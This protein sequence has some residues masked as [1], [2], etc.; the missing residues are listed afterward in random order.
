[1]FELKGDVSLIPLGGEFNIGLKALDIIAFKPYLKDLVPGQ[2]GSL[3][4][5]LNA[6]VSGTMEDVALN[7]TM[8]LSELDFVPDAMPDAALDNAVV[9]IGY[10]FNYNQKQDALSLQKLAVDF[11]GIKVNSAG[12]IIAITQNP[13]LDLDLDVPPLQI[14]QALD[15]IPKALVGDTGK[16][17][18]AGTVSLQAK[19]T[20]P[21]TDA[22]GV[23][24]SATLNLDKVQA[25]ASGYRPALS[26]RLL[27]VGDQLTSEDL[28]VLMGDNRADISLQADKLF[29]KTISVTADVSSERF[30]LDPL[31]KGGAGSAVA[32][33]QSGALEPGKSGADELGPFEIPLH[34]KGVVNVS[35]AV[36]KG[37]T[38]NNFLA[39]YEL[40]D[41]ILTM[42]RMDGQVAGG[43]FSNTARIDLGKKGLVY[44]AE[45][46]LNAIQADPLLSALIPKAAGS[47]LG[48]MVMTLKLSGRGTQWQALS[49]KLNGNG[50]MSVTD[51][52]IVSPGLVNGLAG[53]LQMSSMDEIAF[54]NFKGNF[55]IVDGKVKLDSSITSDELKL[56]P[57]GDIGLDGNLNLS[58]D[59]RL[60][61]QL[62]T[63]LDSRGKVTRYLTDEQGWSQVPLLVTG[64]YSSPRFGLDPKGI[65]SQAKKALTDKLGQELNKLLGGSENGQE[66]PDGSDSTT[67]D[68]PAGQLIQKL[69][70]N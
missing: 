36:W 22:L 17:D 69:F 61:P 38:I 65:K 57:R 23:L 41:N 25:T 19:F 45:L 26:G 5:G 34:A 70:G 4:I 15:S 59:T 46:G 18:P 14:R 58:L 48:S 12:E 60:S 3:K 27:L 66:K 11:N 40:K 51:G 33:D 55:R 37:L 62:A 20:G 6:D 8:S 47:L 54:S 68:N 29:G 67:Q 64:N 35:Q 32:T 28:T 43:S 42:T 2:L 16:L 9:D 39:R 31:L 30:E 49:Q 50:E 24:K 10:D 21:V 7:G 52:R 56:Y 13:T 1:M 53:F 44:S 63:R